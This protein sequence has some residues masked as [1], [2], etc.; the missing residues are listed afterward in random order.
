MPPAETIKSRSNPLFRR[1]RGL[2]EKSDDPL[3]LLEGPK[4][5]EEALR[6]EVEIVEVAAALR[7]EGAPSSRALLAALRARGVPVR[8]LADELLDSLSETK[9]SP[10]I[11]ALA[12][13]PRFDESA[14]RAAGDTAL[15]VVAVGIQN[16]GNLG[17]LLRTSEAAGVTLAYLTEGTADPLSWKGLRGS[18]GSALRLPHVRGGDALGVLKRLRGQGLGIVATVAESGTPYSDARFQRPLA[19]VLGSEGSGLPPELLRQ[20]DE[21]VTIPLRPPVES[22][23]VGVAAGILLFAAARK[24]RR[25]RG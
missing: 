25:E 20:A 15:V 3:C 19:M 5:L 13:R 16:P 11:L 21:R 14:L 22:L 24:H 10:G 2:K 8:C 12:R 4:L 23:N 7:W 9:T 18:M 1:L 17:S 6:A